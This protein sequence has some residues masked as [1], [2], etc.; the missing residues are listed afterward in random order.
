M[1]VHRKVGLERSLR[2][3]YRATR[4]SPQVFV[5]KQQ[6][7]HQEKR[8]S[9]DP[10]IQMIIGFF[11]TGLLGA[12]LTSHFE[13]S[14]KD[15]EIEVAR[16]NA[17]RDARFSTLQQ[18]TELIYGRRTAADLVV[19]AINRSAPM[20][21]VIARKKAYDQ[22][23]VAWNTQLQSTLF[24]IR[25]ATS[26]AAES[27]FEVWLN[28]DLGGLLRIQ[29]ACVTQAFDVKSKLRRTV[30]C[31]WEDKVRFSHLSAAIQE[32]SY[33][34]TDA[35]AEYVYFDPKLGDVDRQKQMEWAERRIAQHCHPKLP[36]QGG[37]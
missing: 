23:Y 25:R 17:E 21:E 19:S 33:Y 1:K 13:E 31:D 3:G 8:W 4:N 6:E 16:A 30:D 20:A 12:F 36:S 10:I 18:L 26:A 35:F 2:N 37:T 27:K 28:Q 24:K 34:V 15:R 7:D 32:C 9:E 22:A 11:L 14:A 29:D 5:L